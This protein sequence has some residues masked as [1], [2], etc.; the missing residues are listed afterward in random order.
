[1]VKKTR[2]VARWA[3]ESER[4]RGGET[5]RGRERGDEEYLSQNTQLA[6]ITTN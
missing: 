5:V 1:L 4:E 6:E 3:L 2:K